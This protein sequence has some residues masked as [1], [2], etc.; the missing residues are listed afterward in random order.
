M[1]K[2]HKGVWILT[3]LS[4]FAEARDYKILINEN[5]FDTNFPFDDLIENFV[6]EVGYYSNKE[7]SIE[8]FNMTNR[9]G[10]KATKIDENNIFLSVMYNALKIKNS[11]IF[12]GLEY[13]KFKRDKEQI[14]YY[15]DSSNQTPYKNDVNIKGDKI[16][17]ISEITYRNNSDTI[18]AF[19]RAT[20]TPSTSLDIEQNTEIFPNATTG[21]NYNGSTTLDLSYK[22]ESEIKWNM[23]KYLNIGIGGSYGFI[24]YEYSYKQLNDQ[25][26]GYIEQK[27]SYDEKTIEYFTKIRFK[28]LFKD[29]LPTI[30]YKRIEIKNS[31]YNDTDDNFIFA[32]VEK[33]F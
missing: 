9:D 25:K 13:E 8:N 22:I 1:K 11:N 4:I 16:N 24:P 28:K 31:K 3:I 18:K 20:V 21:G 7:N 30:G 17:I 33:W 6:I 19:L 15:I 14:G 2:L 10:K 23:G 5:G 26:N 27:I 12:L 29:I 32:G